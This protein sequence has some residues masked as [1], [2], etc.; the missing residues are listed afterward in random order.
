MDKLNISAFGRS[1]VHEAAVRQGLYAAEGLE[2]E[3][4]VTQAS[5]PQVQGLVDDV[6]QIVS[7]NADN[8]FWWAEDNGADLLIIMATES[9][10]N[11]NFVVRPEIT[12]YADLRGKV[13]ATDAA[14]SGYATPLRVLLREGGLAQEGRDYTYIEVGSTEHRVEA[15]RAGQAVGAML[16]AGAE[17]SLADQGFHV[18]DSINRLYTHHAGISAVRRRWAEG[19]PDLLGRYLRAHLRGL[20]WTKDPA[21]AAAVAE[22]TGR[23]DDAA[24]AAAVG[25]PEPPPFSWDGLQEMLN[26]RQ[27]IGLLRGAPDPRRFAD[28]RYYREAAAAL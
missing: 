16:S 15:M 17:R 7:T 12:T 6:F 25:A 27:D 4:D 1:I 26:M 19:H 2:V 14:M 8:I 3:Q 18:L 5:K 9:Q 28:D 20:L 11:Q 21:T 24:L 10:P 13:L 22:M 23:R